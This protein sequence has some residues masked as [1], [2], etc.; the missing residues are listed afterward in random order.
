MKIPL[1]LI[2][3]RLVTVATAQV[4][5][6]VLHVE[7]PAVAPAINQDTLN[8]FDETG[9][10]TGYW[11]ITGKQRPQLPYLPDQKIEE[12]KYVAHKKAG[13]WKRYFPNDT[14][15]SEI[16]FQRGRPDGLYIIYY[17]NGIVEEKG[18]WHRNRNVGTFERNY[19]DGTPQQ[20][21]EFAEDGKR[22]GIQQYY[23][24]N[25]NLAVKV[26]I[27]A[28]KENGLMERYWET[29]ELKMKANYVN[30]QVDASGIKYYTPKK[31]LPPVVVKPNPPKLPKV[32]YSVNSFEPNGENTLLNN[33]KQIL[34]VGKFKGSRLHTGKAYNYDANGLLIDVDVYKEGVWSGK[35]VPLEDER[36]RLP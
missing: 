14:L 1:L 15:Q 8:Q 21:F 30:G 2:H 36:N 19:E 24:P 29:G 13:L 5:N 3:L 25:G 27:L 7:N 28:G 22:Y 20:R 23:H 16:H 4:E 33:N 17:S 9:K 18:M 34:Q 35:A 6:P 32:L 26:S 10:K 12:G 11:I 31:K